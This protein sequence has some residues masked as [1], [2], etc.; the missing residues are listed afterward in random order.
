M[1]FVLAITIFIFYGKVLVRYVSK[2]E[3][4]LESNDKRDGIR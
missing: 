1:P 2:K 3:K 4:I